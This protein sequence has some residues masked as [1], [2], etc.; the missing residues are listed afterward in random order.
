MKRDLGDTK[1]GW[2]GGGPPLDG[3][4]TK[5]HRVEFALHFLPRG[6]GIMRAEFDLQVFW[7]VL[8]CMTQGYE[9][10]CTSRDNQS[11]DFRDSVLAAWD[12]AVF[13]WE[14]LQ[15]VLFTPIGRNPTFTKKDL[16]K[17]EEELRLREAGTDPKRWKGKPLKSGGTGKVWK[18]E[19]L[20]FTNG[21]WDELQGEFKMRPIAEKLVREEVAAAAAETAA[22]TAEVLSMKKK[23]KAKATSNARAEGGAKAEA[24]GA[25]KAGAKVVSASPSSVLHSLLPEGWAVDDVSP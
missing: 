2:R 4:P 1:K 9:N 6:T 20:K 18:Q 3:E 17:K 14:S 23:K 22:L 21:L 8:A 19:W 7:I 25:T 12:R 16:T 13:D 10:H 15:L 24:K 11:K 5:E